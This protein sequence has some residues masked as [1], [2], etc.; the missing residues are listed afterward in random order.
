MDCLSVKNSIQRFGP[1]VDLG[2][3]MLLLGF[4]HGEESHHAK[5]QGNRA[6]RRVSYIGGPITVGTL[7]AE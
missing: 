6:E 3:S 4:F 2:T 5:T 7:I 1:D